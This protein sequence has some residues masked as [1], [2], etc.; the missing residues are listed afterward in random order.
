MS[1][2]VR[3]GA[4]TDATS[5]STPVV[6]LDGETTAA[7]VPNYAAGYIPVNGHRVAVLV[8]GSDRVLIGKRQ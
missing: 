8:S 2:I 6:R 4:V 7:A 3:Y 5:A 1:K